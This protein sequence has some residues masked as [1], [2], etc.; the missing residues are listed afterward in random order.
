MAVLSILTTVWGA[1]YPGRGGGGH[2]GGGGQDGGG[3]GGG[4]GGGPPIPIIKLES[5]LKGDGSYQ[6]T[7]SKFPKLLSR[8]DL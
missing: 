4:G 2:G 6:V 5:E 1:G 3:A 7:Y 8:Q